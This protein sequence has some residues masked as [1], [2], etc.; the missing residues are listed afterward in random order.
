MTNRA[1]DLAA[2][3]TPVPDAFVG[4][5]QWAFYGGAFMGVVVVLLA[6]LLPARVEAPE[7]APVGH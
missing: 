1:E 7:G 4:G 5:L 6:L 2:G 3:G